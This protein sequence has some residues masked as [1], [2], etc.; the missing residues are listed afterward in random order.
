MRHHRPTQFNS[1]PRPVGASA[2]GDV[3]AAT[4]DI[5]SSATLTHP[6]EGIEQRGVVAQCGEP[7]LSQIFS[8]ASIP[9]PISTVPES[10][11]PVLIITLAFY[12]TGAPTNPCSLTHTPPIVGLAVLDGNVSTRIINK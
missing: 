8:I 7:D 4:H 10:T 1:S 9:A 11:L 12:D 3:A 6:L 5:S 2:T